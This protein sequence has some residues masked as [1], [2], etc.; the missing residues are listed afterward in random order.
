MVT[1]KIG[2]SNATDLMLLNS[3]DGITF[4]S[5]SIPQTTVGSG[6]SA[7]PIDYDQNGKMDFAVLNGYSSAVGPLQLIAFGPPWPA[8]YPTPTPSPTPTDSPTATPSPTSTPAPTVTPD[9]GLL[10]TPD[11]TVPGV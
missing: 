1:A 6:D 7:V 2:G 3:G 9:P 8:S 10:A 5:I 4:T 11:P